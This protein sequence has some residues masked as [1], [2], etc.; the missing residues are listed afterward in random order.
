MDAA[1]RLHGRRLLAIPVILLILVVILI[2]SLYESEGKKAEKANTVAV[3]VRET[4][5]QSQQDEITMRLT[6]Y[7][8]QDNR[9]PITLKVYLLQGADFDQ[10]LAQ[11]ASELSE[12]F[13]NLYLVEDSLRG[14]LAQRVALE[15]LDEKYSGNAAVRDRAFYAME[16]T[17][18]WEGAPELPAFYLALQKAD[19]YAVTKDTQTQS[20]YLYQSQLLDNIAANTPARPIA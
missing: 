14:E 1:R 13:P 10:K 5:T 3:L 7:A 20:Y 16:G 4:L 9:A 2:V 12:G 18:F 11:T 15:P 17:P 6:Q 19:T 8:P